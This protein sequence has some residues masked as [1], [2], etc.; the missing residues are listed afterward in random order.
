MR[1]YN[2]FIVNL[3]TYLFYRKI[4]WCQLMPSTLLCLVFSL[5]MYIRQT[6][7]CVPALHTQVFLYQ[8]FFVPLHHMARAVQ[9]CHFLT[10]PSFNLNLFQNKKK[11]DFFLLNQRP[12]FNFSGSEKYS[13]WLRIRSFWIFLL[14]VTCP[15]SG[16]VPNMLFA[17]MA[18]LTQLDFH[19]PSRG[20]PDGRNCSCLQAIHRAR[21]YQTGAFHR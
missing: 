3:P 15:A 5:W 6:Y 4:F 12:V 21:S 11:D 18:F 10:I 7:T 19:D 20:Q 13:L 17:I 2:H 14:L 8:M 9:K 16:A 1:L